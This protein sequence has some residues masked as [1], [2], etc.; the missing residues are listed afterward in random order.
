MKQKLKCS[1]CGKDYWVTMVTIFVFKQRVCPIDKTPMKMSS[2]KRI[3]TCPECNKIVSKD[4]PVEYNALGIRIEG[5]TRDFKIRDQRIAGDN[6][7][8]YDK[9]LVPE[10]PICQ[11]CRNYERISAQATAKRERKEKL[12]IM[13]DMQEI[14]NEVSDADILKF[15]INRKI[16]TDLQERRKAEAYEK[17]KIQREIEGAER[18]AKL[19][20]LQNPDS[21]LVSK[22][23]IKPLIDPETMKAEQEALAKD[24][25]IEEYKKKLEEAKKLKEGIAKT[26]EEITKL[27]KQLEEARKEQK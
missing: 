3:L 13:D 14:P 12:G 25:R 26:D 5:S 24:V 20:Q 23:E 16:Q 8:D 27:K 21:L 15:E 2:N 18:K 4:N 10:E 17:Q 22:E 6:T 1:K 9:V 7:L 11:K 19:K